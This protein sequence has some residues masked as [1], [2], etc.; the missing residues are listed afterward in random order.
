MSFQ[1]ASRDD[2]RQFFE[3][4][5]GLPDGTIDDFVNRLEIPREV[6]SFLILREIDEHVERCRQ[7]H[8]AV[9][10]TDLDGLYDSGHPDLVEREAVRD[11]LALNIL[12]DGL[13]PP[14][15]TDPYT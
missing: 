13:N 4:P 9:R 15:F 11:P 6:R 5:D 14:G 8:G 10:P 1:K 3:A 12:R 2:L 7:R